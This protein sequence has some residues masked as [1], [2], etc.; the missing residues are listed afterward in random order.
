MERFLSVI[1]QND[2]S[3]QTKQT[4]LKQLD[5]PIT[6]NASSDAAMNK[7]ADETDAMDAGPR[8]GGGGRRQQR[9]MARVD[10]S[11][12]S[13]PEVVKVVGLILG[14]PEFQRQ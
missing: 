3:A 9:Q 5:A 7:V 4:L 13:N 2:V 11:T 6:A 8:V 1:V 10:L 12:V 14:S